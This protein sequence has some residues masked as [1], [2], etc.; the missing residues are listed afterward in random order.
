MIKALPKRRSPRCFLAGEA[1][2]VEQSQDGNSQVAEM[3]GRRWTRTEN[4]PI[5]F[6][7]GESPWVRRSSPRFASIEQVE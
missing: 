4:W 1:D 2:P 3:L 5:S 7:N 6:E